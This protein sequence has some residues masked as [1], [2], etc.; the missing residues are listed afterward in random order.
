MT[1][2]FSLH[3]LPWSVYCALAHLCSFMIIFCFRM[4]TDLKATIGVIFEF[5][6]WASLP[7]MFNDRVW[8]RSVSPCVQLPQLEQ[9]FQLTILSEHVVSISATLWGFCDNMRTG[10]GIIQFLWWKCEG[11]VKTRE[12]GK[13]EMKNWKR[14]VEE[15]M[16]V[17]GGRVLVAAFTTFCLLLIIGWSSGSVE[18]SY[19]LRFYVTADNRQRATQSALVKCTKSKCYFTINIHKIKNILLA[20]WQ[21]WRLTG[22]EGTLSRLSRWA[23][24][25]F[26]R[27]FLNLLG[28]Q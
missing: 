16:R 18:L 8:P 21:Q 23:L 15:T 7:D 14:R 9:V 2:L 27:I 5:E 17:V 13:K 19:I 4:E 3:N 12:L 22:L 1:W 6:A 11:K 20:G 28:T 10:G 25:L 26:F 24:N